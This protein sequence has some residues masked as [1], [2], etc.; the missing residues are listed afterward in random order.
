MLEGLERPQSKAV[1][2]KIEMTLS[3]LEPG[4]KDILAVALAD[5]Q[6]WPAN[7]LSTQLR[8]KGLSLADVTITKHR[9]RACAC[10]RG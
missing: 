4:D 2:C 9:R 3:E 5:T 6:N 10:Y 1:Y 8:L 7:T